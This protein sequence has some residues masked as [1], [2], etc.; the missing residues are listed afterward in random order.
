[1]GETIFIFRNTYMCVD[2]CSKIKIQRKTQMTRPDSQV[3]IYILVNVIKFYYAI[4][5][6]SKIWIQ[7]G[8]RLMTIASRTHQNKGAAVYGTI[9]ET[10][11]HKNTKWKLRTDKN[12]S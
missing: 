4:V 6:Y 9:T 1:M 5:C 7:Y 3:G 12:K 10:K 2:K 8:V 11:T